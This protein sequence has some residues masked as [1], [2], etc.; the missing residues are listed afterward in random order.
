MAETV[1]NQAEVHAHPQHLFKK[2]QNTYCVTAT[3]LDYAC[4]ANHCHNTT[5]YIKDCDTY[6][7]SNCDDLSTHLD[8]CNS[9]GC[10]NTTRDV[11]VCY[12]DISDFCGDADILYHS[13]T[14]GDC[15]NRT[16]SF[17]VCF[18]D[19]PTSATK[20]SVAAACAAAGADVDAAVRVILDAACVDRLMAAIRR[21]ITG[22]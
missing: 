10:R 22:K 17:H 21:R 6:L 19:N 1:V 20:M 4:H 16:S 8:I 18:T 9:T 2:L 14:N 3:V 5:T 12:H 11:H 15:R 7:D 13:C